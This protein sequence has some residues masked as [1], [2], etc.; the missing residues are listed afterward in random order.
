MTEAATAAT[1][2]N[3]QRHRELEEARLSKLPAKREQY[4]AESFTYKD[5]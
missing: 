3:Y 2:F 4:F 1:D 5:K